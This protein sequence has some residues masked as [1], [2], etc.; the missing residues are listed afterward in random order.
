MDKLKSKHIFYTV[1]L[2][3]YIGTLLTF[4]NAVLHKVNIPAGDT[5]KGTFALCIKIIKAFLLFLS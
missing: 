4:V 2:F 5:F 3:S 1:Y